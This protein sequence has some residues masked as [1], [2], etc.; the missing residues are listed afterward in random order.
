MNYLKSV[1]T[2]YRWDLQSV[3]HCL[4]STRNC[5]TYAGSLEFAHC[6]HT[7]P[8]NHNKNRLFALHPQYL[9]AQNNHPATTQC[10]RIEMVAHDNLKSFYNSVLSQCISDCGQFLYAGNNYGDIFVFK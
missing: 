1:S 7:P 8:P 3:G 9:N 5:I 4:S 10:P 6:T 2:I